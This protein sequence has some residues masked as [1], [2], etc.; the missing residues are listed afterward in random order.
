[1]AILND[2]HHFSIAAESL[3]HSVLGDRLCGRILPPLR[4]KP[5]RG[6]RLLAGRGG[7]ISDKTIPAWANRPGLCDSTDLA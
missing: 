4:D 7:T 3:S 2:L 6:R 5:A 1:M